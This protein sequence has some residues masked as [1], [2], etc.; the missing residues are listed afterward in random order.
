MS[1]D[2][3]PPLGSPEPRTRLPLPFAIVC[4]YALSDTAIGVI[5]WRMAAARREAYADWTPAFRANDALGTLW[6]V[7]LAW[8]ALID[9]CNVALWWPPFARVSPW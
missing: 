1:S 2:D 9:V 5:A 4:A 8:L 3:A 6:P 7:L